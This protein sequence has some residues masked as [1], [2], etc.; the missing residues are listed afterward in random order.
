MIIIAKTLDSHSRTPRKRMLRPNGD[1]VALS[2]KQPRRQIR[3]GKLRN[4]DR[5]IDLSACERV[6]KAL[7]DRRRNGQLDMSRFAPKH[8][9]ERDEKSVLH[10][11]VA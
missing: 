7:Y 3:H 8:F 10:V 2:I 1:D 6:T 4:C 5:Q 11:V 9:D